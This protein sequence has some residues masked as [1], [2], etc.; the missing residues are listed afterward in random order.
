MIAMNHGLFLGYVSKAAKF[1]INKRDRPQAWLTIYQPNPKVATQKS[2]SSPHAR[3]GIYVT[4]VCFDELATQVRDL[5]SE[6]DFVVC[7]YTVRNIFTGN[8]LGHALN[9]V[10]VYKWKPHQGAEKGEDNLWRWED[11]VDG[12]LADFLPS[13]EDEGGDRAWSLGAG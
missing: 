10:K 1:K 12:N 4:F 7:W 2:A 8:S 11:S 13:E 6:G 5:Y 9:L 3:R